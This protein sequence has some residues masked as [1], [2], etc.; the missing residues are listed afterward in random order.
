MGGPKL[1]NEAAQVGAVGSVY[2]NVVWVAQESLSKE[3]LEHVDNTTMSRVVPQGVVGD[4]VLV[5]LYRPSDIVQ[6]VHGE[7]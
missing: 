4:D 7:F 2:L 3:G 6:N 1:Q 5:E